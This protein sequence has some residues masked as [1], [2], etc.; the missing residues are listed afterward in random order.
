MSVDQEIEKHLPLLSNEEKQ[1]LLSVIKS[2]LAQQKKSKLVEE[3]NRDIDDAM[4]RIDNGE[5]T[6]FED[7]E[8][9]MESW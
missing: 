1:A 5:F 9:E 2:F 7:V 4:T 3:Y 6:T 8:K